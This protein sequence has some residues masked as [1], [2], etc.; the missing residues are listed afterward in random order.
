MID[1]DEPPVDEPPR[2]DPPGDQPSPS[3]PPRTQRRSKRMK[4]Y[5]LKEVTMPLSK[6][7]INAGK[8]SA[9]RS[10]LS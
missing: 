6:A 9:K 2:P 3:T 8:P 10:S 7:D 1:G 4:Q 5:S